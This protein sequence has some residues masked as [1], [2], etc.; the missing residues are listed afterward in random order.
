MD[1]GPIRPG[2]CTDCANVSYPANDKFDPSATEGT[3]PDFE[4]KWFAGGARSVRGGAW[5]NSLGLA[6]SQSEVEIETYTS[7][8]VGRTYRSL[9]GRCAR[10]P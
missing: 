3:I 8:P 6:N 10:D 7:Y 2:P 9:G 4:H 1:E 5:D